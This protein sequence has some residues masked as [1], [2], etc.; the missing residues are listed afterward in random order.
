MADA[1]SRLALASQG[2][3]LRPPAGWA[4]AREPA[5]SI[6]LAPDGA[7]ALGMTEAESNAPEKIVAALEPLL[8]RLAI[9]KVKTK[10]LKSRLKK[11]QSELPADGIT[12]QLW[13]V[14]KTQQNQDPVM[15]DGAGA[16]L[17]LVAAL[18]SGKAVVGVS[19]VVKPQGDPLVPAVMDSLKTLR[20][21]P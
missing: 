15:H 3:S 5:A 14:D 10:S 18:P 4:Y 12:L 8:T 13:E 7:A 6:A 21:A 20:S 1:D 16:A 17:V 2:A 9:T 11:A 19:F